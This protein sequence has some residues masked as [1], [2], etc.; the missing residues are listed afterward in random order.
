LK[1]FT[2]ANKGYGDFLSDTFTIEHCMK[3]LQIVERSAIDIEENVSDQDAREI[4]R[5]S[6]FDMHDE[7]PSI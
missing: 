4:G 3:V 2:A 7:Q 1:Q 5:C 6:A